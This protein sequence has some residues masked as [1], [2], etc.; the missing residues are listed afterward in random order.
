M[1]EEDKPKFYSQWRNMATLYVKEDPIKAD[2]RRSIWQGGIREPNVIS[3]I[4]K[5]RELEW[6]A[7]LNDV[8]INVKSYL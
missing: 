1:S 3:R 2:T 7:E 6:R 5:I 4:K 8:T